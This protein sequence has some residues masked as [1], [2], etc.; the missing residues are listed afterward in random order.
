MPH[1]AHPARPPLPEDGLRG[2]FFAGALTCFCFGGGLFVAVEM[3][4]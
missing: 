2:G 4:L 1:P 3:D